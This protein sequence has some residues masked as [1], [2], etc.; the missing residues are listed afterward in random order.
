MKSFLNKEITYIE[1]KE[2]EKAFRYFKKEPKVTK[3]TIKDY[4]HQVKFFTN[5]DFSFINAYNENDREL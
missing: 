2:I 5:N 4:F 1:D 3:E